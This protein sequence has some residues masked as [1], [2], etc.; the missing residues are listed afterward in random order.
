[1]KIREEEVMTDSPFEIPQSLRDLAEQNVKQT[2]AAYDQ[3]SDFMSKSMTSW[4]G[5]MP[6]SPAAVNFKDVQGRAMELATEHAQSTFT[7]AGKISSAK[8]IQEIMALQTQ[9]TQERLQAFVL[10]TQ[11]FYGLLEETMKKIQRG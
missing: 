3:L 5:A 7:F 10:H 6:A 4:M 8:T 11:E 9:F 2:H 1:M